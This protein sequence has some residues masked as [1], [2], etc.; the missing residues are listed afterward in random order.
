MWDIVATDFCLLN[1]NNLPRNGENDYE[2]SF[3]WGALNIAWYD[4]FILMLWQIFRNGHAHTQHLFTY[5]HTL[6]WMHIQLYAHW[7]W[8]FGA[9]L[10]RKK[11]HLHN[12]LSARKT[13]QWCSFSSLCSIN[14]MQIWSMLCLEFLFFVSSFFPIVST[15]IQS[16]T[17]E[18]KLNWK[19]IPC[20]RLASVK[21]ESRLTAKCRSLSPN[22]YVAVCMILRLCARAP[23][24]HSLTLC[25]SDTMGGH[26]WESEYACVCV[27]DG[28]IVVVRKH[29]I[30][31]TA[32]LFSVAKNHRLPA[33][34]IGRIWRLDRSYA[35]IEWSRVKLR[36]RIRDVY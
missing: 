18:K 21:A 8:L 31:A 12:F 35:T 7:E 1:W 27:C 25:P 13:T 32:K 15:G 20:A 24:Q 16:Q 29:T 5:T 34:S 3:G 6:L 10:Q 26:G 33:T 23:T 30:K 28:V 9:P 2:W 36:P 14:Q 4:F 17:R 22:E 19:K 11:I